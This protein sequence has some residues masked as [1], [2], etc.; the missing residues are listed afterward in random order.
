[1]RARVQSS[2]DS[3]GRQG[4]Q[5]GAR[6]RRRRRGRAGGPRHSPWHRPWAPISPRESRK[7]T[8][9]FHRKGMDRPHPPSAPPHEGCMADGNIGPG[10]ERPVDPVPP[11][12]YG[13]PPPPGA[14]VGRP[15]FA[16]DFAALPSVLLR[17]LKD[18]ANGLSA[19]YKP[20][21]AAMITGLIIGVATAIL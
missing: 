13:A 10:G 6:G 18:P 12:G 15:A 19:S 14:S 11:A 20:G 2:G 17:I 7:G 3:G 16:Y 9:P 1:K 5:R 8:F 21:Q 4:R